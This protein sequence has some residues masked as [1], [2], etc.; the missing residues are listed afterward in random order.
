M[1]AIL[2]LFLRLFALLTGNV[3]SSDGTT[4]PPGP[5]WKVASVT[6][7][8]S[9]PECCT[10]SVVDQTECTDF[11]ACDYQGLFA[12]LP[13]RQSKE[14]VQN[15]AVCAF[16]TTHG[17][18][19][20]YKNQVI[21]IDKRSTDGSSIVVEC[22]VVDTCADSDCNGCCTTNAGQ[23]GYLIDMEYWTVLRSYGNIDAADGQVYFQLV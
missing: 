15:N 8:T 13:D 5:G 11:S 6:T 16:F 20:T 7:Y 10:N 3:G 14:W 9:Y 22:N 4:V 2:S 17:D 19:D 23:A 12:F 21:R 1:G 18:L